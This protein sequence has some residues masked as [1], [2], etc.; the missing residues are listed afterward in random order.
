MLACAGEGLGTGAL[1]FGS[2]PPQTYLAAFVVRSFMKP[3]ARPDLPGRECGGGAGSP[4]LDIPRVTF[5]PRMFM[6]T[7]LLRCACLCLKWSFTHVATSNPQFRGGV[8][9]F[10]SPP[11]QVWGGIGM[12]A[13]LGRE[14]AVPQS[15]GA[16]FCTLSDNRLWSHE[17]Y[18]HQPSAKSVRVELNLMA[19]FKKI[20]IK[21][22]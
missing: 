19:G 15:M 12:G 5:C 3:G 1:C 13:S 2:I 6:K 18:L 7:I 8:C 16:L 17:P 22:T 21:V 11:F 9:G 20:R 10:C 4:P 14:L